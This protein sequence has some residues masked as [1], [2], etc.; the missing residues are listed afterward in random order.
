MIRRVAQEENVLLRDTAGLRAAVAPDGI[1]GWETVSDNC[2]LH[3]D[4]FAD[5]AAS[6]LN[7]LGIH[8][9][10]ANPP[11]AVE[12]DHFDLVLKY[13]SNWL[14][15][16]LRSE[17]EWLIVAPLW[18]FLRM[19]QP[20]IEP[21]FEA[22]IDERPPAASQSAGRSR[23]LLLAAWGQAHWLA[24]DKARAE[25]I[26]E[27]ARSASSET[28]LPWVWKG[29]YDVGAGRIDGAKAAFSK[30]LQIEPGRPDAQAYLHLL[31]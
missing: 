11:P 26:N 18:R 23:S 16:A 7:L 25:A 24:G 22:W 3:L 29:L 28:A 1:L 13:L 9:P 4:L 21:R 6:D 12:A 17:S 20:M 8:V 2:H 5:E 27:K 14:D 15:G 30:A 31:G 19:N 10:G